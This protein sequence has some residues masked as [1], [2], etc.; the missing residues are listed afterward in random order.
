M[1]EDPGLPALGIGA[2][3]GRPHLKERKARR[4]PQ[5]A[6]VREV[7]SNGLEGC[8]VPGPREDGAAF[9]TA[10]FELGNG[11]HAT[12]TGSALTSAERPA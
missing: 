2:E 4:R 1:N 5:D 11:Q 12:Q 9:A 8:R 3:S 6:G 10:L 7:R